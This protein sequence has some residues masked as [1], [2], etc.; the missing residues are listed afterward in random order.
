MKIFQTDSYLFLITDKAHKIR[1]E[2]VFI[3]HPELYEIVANIW[4]GRWRLELRNLFIPDKFKD[5]PY[6]ESTMHDRL[7]REI[8][9]CYPLYSIDEIS[10]ALSIFD[11][12]AKELT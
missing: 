2:S 7:V 4:A 10:N 12:F 3:I 5:I 8:R 1:H 9:V 6:W 11:N